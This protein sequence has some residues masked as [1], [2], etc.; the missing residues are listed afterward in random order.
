MVPDLAE[1]VLGHHSAGFFVVGTTPGEL[2][3]LQ[4]TAT[5]SDRRVKHPNPLGYYLLTYPVS[6]NCRNTVFLH[7][8]SKEITKAVSPRNGSVAGYSTKKSNIELLLLF[9][10]SLAEVFI[11][12]AIR[13]PLGRGKSTGKLHT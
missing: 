6:L 9:M 8:V 1:T 11:F 10:S 13:T 5:F 2:L 4:L 3:P 7:L 12:D